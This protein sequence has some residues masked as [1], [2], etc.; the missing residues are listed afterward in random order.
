MGSSK[1]NEDTYHFYI[2]SHNGLKKFCEM[3]YPYLI[4]KK[5]T[6]EII[7]EALRLKEEIKEKGEFIKDNFFLFDQLRHDLHKY[8]RKGPKDLKPWK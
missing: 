3:I 1:A 5:K 4:F 6:C 2:G 8:A 7:M